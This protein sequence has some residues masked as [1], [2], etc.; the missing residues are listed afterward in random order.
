MR[1]LGL[2]SSQVTLQDTFTRHFESPEISDPWRALFGLAVRFWRDWLAQ[3]AAAPVFCI[4]RPN[5]I[6]PATRTSSRQSIRS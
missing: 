2:P 6:M 3:Q 1:T 4:A 5:D